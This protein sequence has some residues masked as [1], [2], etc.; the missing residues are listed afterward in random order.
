MKHKGEKY[1]RKKE[2]IQKGDDRKIFGEIK[3]K[4]FS[5]RKPTGPRGS[6]KSNSKQRKPH[7]E[8]Q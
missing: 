8:I 5:D 6:T 1:K 7:L 2:N 3:G 4:I